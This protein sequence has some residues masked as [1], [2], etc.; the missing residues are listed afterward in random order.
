M[1][2]KTEVFYSYRYRSWDSNVYY[3]TR[4]RE[5]SAEDIAAGWGEWETISEQKYNEILT[6]LEG[7]HSCH[8]QVQKILCEV[9]E[10]DA[11][12]PRQ[13]IAKQMHNAA[14]ER[15]HLGGR[16]RKTIYLAKHSLPDGT[17]S[18]W[19]RTSSKVFENGTNRNWPDTSGFSHHVTAQEHMG[20]LYDYMLDGTLQQAFD[21]HPD[22]FDMEPKV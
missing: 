14:I 3:G 8:Y 18:P 22:Y 4:N 9:Q 12:D 19:I 20:T 11:F 21:Y 13:W 5:F 2:Q 16:D 10:D 7:K 15:K 1:T 6:Y 17:L